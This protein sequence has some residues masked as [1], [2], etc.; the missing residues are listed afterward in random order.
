MKHDNVAAQTYRDLFPKSR[1]GLPYSLSSESLQIIPTTSSGHSQ[2]VQKTV[3]PEEPD[4]HDGVDSKEQTQLVSA[5][6]NENLTEV[7]RLLQ[8]G[9]DPNQSSRGKSPLMY[10]IDCG[11]ETIVMKLRDRGANINT[12]PGS[13]SPLNYAIEKRAEKMV[14]LLCQL[15]VDV[16]ASPRKS[17]L[18]PLLRAAQLKN[19]GMVRTLC[20]HGAKVNA[21]CSDEYSALHYAVSIRYGPSRDKVCE[22]LEI[23]LKNNADPNAKDVEG[24]SPLH[25]AIQVRDETCVRFMLDS[26][27]PFDLEAKD[28]RGRTPLYFAI[29]K[30]DYPLVE[31]CLSKNPHIPERL[32]RDTSKPLQELINRKRRESTQ[33]NDSAARTSSE[34][35]PEHPPFGSLYRSFSTVA[36]IPASPPKTSIFRRWSLFGKG[37]T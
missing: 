35:A 32:P 20:Q 7:E 30:R 2:A 23:L 12:G 13:K 31:L 11:I 34:A 36:H 37:S 29:D 18:T 14:K 4:S 19:P 22:I 9:A 28:N 10:A 1:I 3:R 25:H 33:S 27:W 26:S 24:K 6:L 8:Q 5:I 15:G 17:N 21:R 16:E